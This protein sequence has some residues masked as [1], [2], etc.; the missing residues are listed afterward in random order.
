M[1]LHYVCLHPESSWCPCLTN[2]G[3]GSKTHEQIKFN[4]FCKQNSWNCV[5]LKMYHFPGLH[6]KHFYIKKSVIGEN[7]NTWIH[8]WTSI[9]TGPASSDPKDFVFRILNQNPNSQARWWQGLSPR[10]LQAK[11]CPGSLQHKE[12]LRSGG[13]FLATPRCTQLLRNY[14]LLR[15]LDPMGG[16]GWNPDQTYVRWIL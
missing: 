16:W 6:A 9:K 15:S 11:Y 5:L 8:L 4:V 3:A 13:S 12:A 10:R 2:V 1:V 7:N 14:S